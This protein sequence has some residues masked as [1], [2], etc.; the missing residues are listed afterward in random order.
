M[1]PADLNGKSNVKMAD[2]LELKPKEQSGFCTPNPYSLVYIALQDSDIEGFEKHLRSLTATGNFDINHVYDDPHYGTLLDIACQALN[3]SDFV[4]IL[5]Q[6]GANVNQVNKTRKKAPLHFAVELSDIKTLQYL[7]DSPNIDVNILDNTGGTVLH[8]ACRLEKLDQVKTLLNHR[9]IRVNALNK[10]NQTAIQLA[11]LKENKAIVSELL[12]HPDIDIDSIKTLSG[13]SIRELITDRLPDLV[14]SLP[15]P[16][17]RSADDKSDKVSKLFSYLR[18]HD[19]DSFAK[20]IKE[21]QKLVNADDGDHTFLQYA[22]E[23]G[24]YDFVALLVRCGADV[25]ATCATNSKTG[26][27]LACKQGYYKIVQLL[28][29]NDA[30]SLVPV[31][32]ESI[33][34][35]VIKNSTSENASFLGATNEGRDYFKCLKVILRNGPANQLNINQ[36]DLKG[37]T[38]LHYAAKTG[39]QD[40]IFLLLDHGAYIGTRNVFGE[41]ALADLPPKILEAY[42]DQCV[43]TN[44]K[45]PREDNFE[46]IFKYN[47]LVPPKVPIY[48]KSNSNAIEDVESNDK[49]VLPTSETD[50]L[51]YMSQS[52]ELRP[53][54]IHP[55]L[56]SFVNLKWYSIRRFFYYNLAF[57]ASFWLL[58]TV[59]ILGFYDSGSGNLDL[60]VENKTGSWDSFPPLK[61]KSDLSLLWCALAILLGI[62][63]L[64][65]LF[66]LFVSPVRYIITIE[67]WLEIFLIIVTAMILFGNPSRNSRNQ[68]SAIGILLSWGEL[69]LLIGRHPSLST[70]IEMFKTVSNNFLKFLAWYS[71]LILAFALSFYSLF[72]DAGTEDSNFL[73]PGMSI[74]KTVVMLTGEFDSGSIPFG[75]NPGTSHILFVLFVFLIAIVLFNLLNGLAVSD[76]QEI[77]ADAELV[78]HVSR[79]KLISYIE[80]M[81]LGNPVPIRGFAAQLKSM[82]C[83]VPDSFFACNS[84]RHLA[85]I[86]SR[87]TNLFPDSIPDYEIHVLP[88][89][90]NKVDLAQTGHRRKRQDLDSYESSCFATC[91]NF[92]MEG[93]IVKAAKEILN[94]QNEDTD[95]MELLQ[96]E[97]KKKLDE[98]GQRLQRLETATQESQK[99]LGEIFSLL[100]KKSKKS[101]SDSD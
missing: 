53:L 39:N 13:E 93:S 59:Y 76:T 82:C 68:T 65:E 25:N 85:R 6:N 90:E 79:V 62:L 1:H 71:I 54:L 94:K 91:Q 36:G 100:K 45:L 44:D 8:S 72:K 58:L 78:G 10:K 32:E 57:Y 70:N 18:Q 22:C 2:D 50:P 95:K 86:F 31:N 23:F 35:T 56:T 43:G 33:L 15:S 7:L 3:Y 19:L 5:V 81:A 30:V 75:S 61:T 26:L 67:N 49:A 24:L 96:L 80:T 51:L 84:N 46:I 16:K 14:S 87:R 38:V 40:L 89:Q 66:Q 63:V 12:K 11:I 99:L 77:R 21:D 83:C 101:S 69:V 29:G 17:E 97:N 60:N 92:M 41:P 55:V 20:L 37:N 74:F 64:R 42:M 47:F 9:K 73:D 98:Y 52:P 48:G 28:I 4:R 88:N 27:V 34:Q